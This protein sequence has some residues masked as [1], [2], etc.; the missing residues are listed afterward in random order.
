VIASAARRLAAVAALAAAVLVP[1]V[2]VPA[3]E[4]PF[5]VPKLAA[6]EVTGAL[7]F[8]AFAG[9]LHSGVATPSWPRLTLT[10][11]ALVLVTTVAAW[12]VAAPAGAPYAVS[13]M[14][15]WTA[16]FALA[17]GAALAS[18]DREGGQQ[19]LEAVAGSAAVVS[20]IGIWQHLELAP[21]A[22]PVISA[23]GSTFGNRNLAAEAVAMSLAFG[24]AAAAGARRPGIRWALVATLVLDVVYLA[25]TRARGAWLGAALAMVTTWLLVRPRFSRRRAALAAGAAVLV[26][27]VAILPGRLNPR[28][29]AD[30]KRFAS[31]AD[32]LQ[33]SFDPRSTA[34]RT[35][36]G[37]W[38][39][40]A[41]MW[42]EH[43]IFGVGPGNWPVFFPRYAEPGATR[44][45]VLS[46][47]LAPR[48]AHDDLIERAGETG[49][50]GLAALGVLVAGAI[51]AVRRR[52]G[53]DEA[54]AR[55]RAVA[56]AA[57]L[58]ALSG[59]ALTGFPL[60]MPA[61]IALSGLALGLLAGERPP[62]ARAEAPTVRRVIGRAAVAVAVG[63]LVVAGVR[64]ERQIRGSYWLGQA[65][66]ALRRDRGPTGALLALPLLDRAA[67][68]TPGVFRVH[69]RAAQTMLRLRRQ[70]EAAQ[71]ARRALAIEPLSPNAW[72][73]LAAAELE[74][75]Q[76][77]EARA[78]AARALAVLA[79]HP[80]ALFIDARGAEVTADLAGAARSWARLRAIAA[81]RAVDQETAAAART[82]LGSH[83]PQP[84]P[85]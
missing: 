47:Y 59:A 42:R 33:A 32:V 49:V 41:A 63:L 83:E 27:L 18:S 58:A 53:G 79:D 10:G 57:A 50:L 44:D 3:L 23:P 40:G 68:A 36:L 5:L 21:L 46:A 55:P 28:Y 78:D 64:A 65:E 85:D 31:G 61:T 2:H 67:A 24:W 4:A 60:E 84:W 72:A 35:R 75:G 73:T 6:L 74:A 8:L 9:H 39:R 81:S 7:A 22:I 11:A 37:L 17:C 76:P 43:A 29:V 62:G 80:F 13:A 82:L 38:R 16:L 70:A 19:L 77:A 26:G 45:G 51:V 66:R 34:L 20:A 48:Q 14:S 52:L 30:T 1:L 25:A 15:R 71:A 56:A 12:A 54:Q 69:L